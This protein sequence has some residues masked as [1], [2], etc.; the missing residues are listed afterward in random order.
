[1]PHRRTRAADF[2]PLLLEAVRLEMVGGGLARP[3]VNAYC[4][5][6]RSMFRWAVSRQL[7]KPDLLV[8]LS[9]LKPLRAGRS[10]AREP[11]PIEPVPLEHV[12][13]VLPLLSPPVRAAVEVLR[14]TG[15]RTGEILSMRTG[16][17]DRSAEPAAPLRDR[18][19]LS[20]KGAACVVRLSS[21]SSRSFPGSR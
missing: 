19:V 16:E 9:A 10:A 13:A 11:K 8:A 7:V 3:T 2:G 15:A 21:L 17:I 14:L 12:E 5:R 18:A 6:I 4:G 1:M 20:F